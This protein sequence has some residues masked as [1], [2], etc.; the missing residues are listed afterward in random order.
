M[1]RFIVDIH[2]TGE[3]NPSDATTR[4]LNMLRLVD[5]NLWWD[6]PSWLKMPQESWPVN[7]SLE[8]SKVK[9]EEERKKVVQVNAA[10]VKDTVIDSSGYNKWSKLLRVTAYVLL[11]IIKT[12]A[13]AMIRKQQSVAKESKAWKV[14]LTAEYLINRISKNPG[15]DIP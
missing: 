1:S 5:N 15:G 7:L 9:A 6:G 13:L 10:I 14:A 11:F 4:G 2:D 12:C 8:P 3:T